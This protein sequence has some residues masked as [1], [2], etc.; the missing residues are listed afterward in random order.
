MCEATGIRHV[1]LGFDA[2]TPGGNT[3]EAMARF[4]AE[5]LE[6]VAARYPG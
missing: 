5:V 4:M 3:R 1:V 6:P 2:N